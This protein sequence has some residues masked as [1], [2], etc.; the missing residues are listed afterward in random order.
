[1]TTNNLS[2]SDTET[3]WWSLEADISFAKFALSSV[4]LIFFRLDSIRLP[5]TLISFSPDAYL[6]QVMYV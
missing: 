6:Y 3:T 1:M 2:N 5:T 4:A